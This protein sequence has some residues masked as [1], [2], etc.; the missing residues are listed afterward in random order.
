M[1]P[2]GLLKKYLFYLVA[3]NILVYVIII[4]LFPPFQMDDYYIFTIIR[5]NPGHPIAVLQN[6]FFSLYF[7]PLSYFAFFLDYY[8]LNADAYP[9]KYINLIIHILVI[10]VFYFSLIKISDVLKFKASATLIFLIS[11]IFSFSYFS[12]M[13]IY[14]I[15]DKTELLMFCFYLISLFS[16]FQYHKSQKYYLLIFYCIFYLLSILSKQSS[17]HLP[18]LILFLVFLLRKKIDRKLIKN[19]LVA[20]LINLSIMIFYL[21]VSGSFYYDKVEIFRNLWIKPFSIAGS[22]LILLVPYFTKHI[23]LFF[24]YNKWIA[25]VITAIAFLIFAVFYKKIKSGYIISVIIFCIIIFFPKFLGETEPSIRSMSVQYFWLLIAF[26][27]IINYFRFNVNKI[28]LGFLILVLAL[29][30]SV[31]TFKSNILYWSKYRNQ[32]EGLLSV[33]K[34]NN[35]LVILTAMDSFLIPYQLYSM[36][37]STFGKDSVVVTPFEYNEH[38]PET[39][40]NAGSIVSPVNCESGINNE[41][42]ITGSKGKVFLDYDLLNND[43]SKYTIIKKVKTASRGYDTLIFNI[44]EEYL[45]SGYKY[46]FFNG[47]KWCYISLKNQSGL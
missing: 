12:L 22:M 45:S 19:I 35:K 26:F 30:N 23:Y 31:F 15:C 21:I 13:W 36:K 28:F 44:P 2:E 42:I 3:V 29:M 33:E 8:L 27:I 38:F 37:N 16:V 7:R 9:I 6:Y 32:V 4:S 47:Y 18:V 41:V 1:L 40:N 43:L 5:N 34:E 25:F 46:I 39:G 11:L 14:W 24:M 20:T 17:L 10:V